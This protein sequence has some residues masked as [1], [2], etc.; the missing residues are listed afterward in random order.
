MRTSDMFIGNRAVR[1]TRQKLE[2]VYCG[3]TI[4]KGGRYVNAKREEVGQ[5]GPVHADPCYLD[6]A[7]Q[8]GGET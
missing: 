4:R 2:C 3:N 6:V 8:K 7:T 5:Y 1:T